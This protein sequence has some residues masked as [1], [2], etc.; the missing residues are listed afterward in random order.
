MNS[1]AAIWRWQEKGFFENVV[2]C[3]PQ[4]AKP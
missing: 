4:G 2:L 1:L 3:S